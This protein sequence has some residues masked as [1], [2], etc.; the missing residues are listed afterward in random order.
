M[1]GI[2]MYRLF[3]TL[4]FALLVF[5]STSFAQAQIADARVPLGYGRLITNDALGDGQDRWRSG[6]VSSSRIRGYSWNGS[7]P[8]T[9]GEIIE[10]RL[11]AENSAPSNLVRPAVGDRPFSGAWSLGAHS[12]FQRSGFEFAVGADLVITGPQTGLGQLQ[13]AFHDLIGVPAQSAAVQAGQIPNGF[14]PT[15]VIE[16][17][18]RFSIGEHAS[19]RPFVEGRLGAETIIRAGIDLRIGRIGRGELLVRD[20]VTGQRYRTIQQ[21]QTGSSFVLGADIAHVAESIYLP[22]ASYTLSPSRQRLRAGVHWQGERA[23]TF[24][25][26]TWLG[27]EFVGQ[28]EGQLLGSLRLNLDF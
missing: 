7:L 14:H 5:P 8:E 16:S 22:S 4:A 2:P 27:E 28:G 12:H 25:G 20:P 10:F 6:S 21:L 3:A 18:R 9:F 15:L 17:G 23:S 13:S 24:Y 11:M 26:V 19:L 1:S